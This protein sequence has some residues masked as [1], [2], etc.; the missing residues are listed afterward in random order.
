[1]NEY[2]GIYIT[3]ND[4]T[5]LLDDE[6][7]QGGNSSVYKATVPNDSRVF[8]IKILQTTKSKEKKERL[9]SLESGEHS[10]IKW[11]F[12]RFH[13]PRHVL[14]MKH[15]PTGCS[16]FSNDI[17]FPQKKDGTRIVGYESSYRRI[18]WDEPCPTI[19]MRN[20]AISSQRNVHPGQLRL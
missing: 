1:M 5:Y 8:A 3:I 14:W 18:K 13:D 17:Y 11:H 10:S 19:T 6:I 16:A 9:P 12:A 2:K 7:D 20:D 15:T 4:S